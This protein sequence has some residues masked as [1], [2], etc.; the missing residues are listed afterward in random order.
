M[1]KY[2][3]VRDNQLFDIPP[4]C[5]FLTQLRILNLVG[6]RLSH[7]PYTLISLKH[8]SAIWVSENQSRPIVEL[9]VGVAR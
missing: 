8:L 4:E 9:Q 2:F 6:N 7:L 3:S 5:G 1:L